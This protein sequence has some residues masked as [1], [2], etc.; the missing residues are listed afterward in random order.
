MNV[1]LGAYIGANVGVLSVGIVG[2]WRSWNVAYAGAGI[3]AA[4]VVG[5][6]TGG[7]IGWAL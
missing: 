1:I 5:L 2:T 3:I 6:V 7:F 4:M